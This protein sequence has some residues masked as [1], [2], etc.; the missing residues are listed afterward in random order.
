MEWV[1]TLDEEYLPVVR[2][3]NSVIKKLMPG[4]WRATYGIVDNYFTTFDDAEAWIKSK[5]T[6]HIEQ[7]EKWR[8]ES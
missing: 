8:D 3:F 5:I 1:K 4:H 7:L 6:E 2:R